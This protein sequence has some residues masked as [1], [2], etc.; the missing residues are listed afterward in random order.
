VRVSSFDLVSLGEGLP[1][2]TFIRAFE[3]VARP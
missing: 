3:Q 2:V 1:V